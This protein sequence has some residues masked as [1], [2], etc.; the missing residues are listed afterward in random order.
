MLPTKSTRHTVTNG[1]ET[2]KESRESKGKEERSVSSTC[3]YIVTT[4]AD[5]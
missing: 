1:M 3:T 5:Y 4:P 2:T